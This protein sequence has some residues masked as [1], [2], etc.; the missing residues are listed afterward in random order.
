MEISKLTRNLRDALEADGIVWLDSSSETDH[1]DLDGWFTHIE[2]TR[3]VDV[4]GREIALCAWGATCI[5]GIAAVSTYGYPDQLECTCEYL[6]GEPHAMEIA[7]ILIM[8]AEKE[9]PC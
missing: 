4:D 2:R 6:D 3:I 9:Q 1:K 7:D 8:L 5:D